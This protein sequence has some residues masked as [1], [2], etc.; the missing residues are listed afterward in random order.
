MVQNNNN[1]HL[2]KIILRSHTVFTIFD[3]HRHQTVLEKNDMNRKICSSSH[4]EYIAGKIFGH[5]A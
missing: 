4:L 2:I 1:N 3:S 5:M